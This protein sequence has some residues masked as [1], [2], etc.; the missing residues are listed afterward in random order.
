[1]NEPV[2]DTVDHLANLD[3]RGETFAARRQRPEYVA[4]VEQCRESV[5][6]PDD[7]LQL[8]TV[9]RT[10]LAV[11]M[12]RIVGNQAQTGYYQQRL[13]TSNPDA[14]HQRIAQGEAL[15][16]DD[17]ARLRAIV[18]HCEGVTV[19]PAQRRRADIEHLTDAGLT[20]AQIVALSE[21]IAFI[22]FE[23]RVISGLA[24]LEA[25]V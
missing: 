22:N 3:S 18:R 16:M 23:A 9:L 25:L 24:Q 6:Q 19:S 14:L 8:S 7:D 4:G 2:I 21:L 10:A 11:R 5:L 13:F 12:A 1:M 20:P 17:P 15:L